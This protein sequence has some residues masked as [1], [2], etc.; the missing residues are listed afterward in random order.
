M[1]I[2][3]LTP[4]QLDLLDADG[5]HVKSVD[6]SGDVARVDQTRTRTGDVVGI[7]T[8]RTSFGDVT[9]LPDPKDDTIYVVSGLVLSAVD[10]RDDVYAPGDLVR[11]DDGNPVG[12]KGLTQ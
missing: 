7:P 12:A 8:Y 5:N 10:G 2:T 1:T 4:H 11:D 6:P 3:N 9:G